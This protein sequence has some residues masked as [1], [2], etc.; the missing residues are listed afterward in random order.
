MTEYEL[1]KKYGPEIAV[2]EL[3][4]RWTTD[5]GDLRITYNTGI[6][7]RNHP[8]SSYGLSVFIAGGNMGHDP[9][10]AGEVYGPADLPSGYE[11]LWIH[12]HHLACNEANKWSDKD[13]ISIVR[14][15]KN[16]GY[17]VAEAARQ[18]V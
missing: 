10:V 17:N 6:L 9:L 12:G 18:E 3:H 8:Q 4:Y 13:E 2:V 15:A 14:G 16:A 5:D 11:M 1:A 7:T